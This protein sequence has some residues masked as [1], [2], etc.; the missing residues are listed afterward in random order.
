VPAAVLRAAA[1]AA[2]AVTDLTGRR[3]PLNRKL[4]AQVLAAGWQCDPGKAH[5]RLGFEA[6]TRLSE[7]IDRAAR[8]Y[9]EHGWL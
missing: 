8:W 7:S 1:R 3:L 9:L 5:A 6:S 4:A 2:D